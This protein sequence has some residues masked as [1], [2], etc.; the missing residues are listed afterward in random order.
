MWAGRGGGGGG[1]GGGGGGGGGGKYGPNH[2]RPL[3]NVGNTIIIKIRKQIEVEN[4]HEIKS[5]IKI[6]FISIIIIRRK[7]NYYVYPS[8][9]Y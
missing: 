1:V 3:A 4:I 7:C 8:N 2:T 6:E 5:I 9:S